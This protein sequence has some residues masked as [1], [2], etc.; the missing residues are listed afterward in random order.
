MLIFMPTHRRNWQTK[1]AWVVF[2]WLLLTLTPYHASFGQTTSA[3]LSPNERYREVSR[4]MAQRKYEEAVTQSKALIEEFPNYHN[5]YFALAM[6]ASEA[7]QL[8][9]A[10][11]WL[12][13]Q[14]ARIP[15]RPM[16]RVGLAHVSNARSDFSA[17]IE[18]YQNYLQLS[19]DD[20]RAA[21]LLAS[22]YHNQKKS[23]AGENYFKSLLAVRPYSAT[24]H[25]GLGVLYT[26]LDRRAEALAELNQVVGLQ[27]NTII[28]YSN[29]AFVLSREGRNS[30]GI[31]KLLLCLPL[32]QA[33]PDDLLERQL[34]TQLGDLYRRA[35]N[36]VAAEHTLGRLLELARAADDQRLEEAALG[37]LGSLHFRQSNY[38]E[39]LKYWRLALDVSRTIAS[40]KSKSLTYPHRHLDGI[41]SVYY[42]LGD[43]ESAERTYLEALRL[44][45]EAKDE[46]HQSRLLISLGDLY[47]ERG[48]FSEA[49]ST[50]QLAMAK[51]EKLA[52]LASRLGAL[53]SLS[54]LHR[55]LGDQQQALADV[56][57]AL[58]ILEGLTEPLWQGH[59]WNNLGNLHL[60]FREIPAAIIAFQKTLAIDQTTL[61]PRIIWD[62]N[63]GLADAYAQLGQL[64]NA[65][66]HYELA[67][68]QME[69]TR[70]NLGGEVEKA[71]FFQDKIAVY[72]KLIALLVNAPTKGPRFGDVVAFNYVERAR[73]RAFLDLLAEARVDVNENTTPDLLK[74]QRE[75]Q[76]RISQ[77]TSQLIKERSAEAD[78]QNKLKV[79]DLEN[80]LGQADA[81][82]SDWLRELRRR[83]P[84][85]AELKYPEP[86]TLVETQRMLDHET[87]LLSYSLGESESF[88]FAVSRTD[89]QVKRLPAEKTLEANVQKLL[90]AIT[91]KNNPAPAE[92]R[93]H[94][95]NLS[96]QLLQ[97]VSRMLDGKKRLI[98]VADGALHRLPF[99]VLFQPGVSQR[100]DLRQSP[101]LIRQFAI[102]YAP[103]AS[104]LAQLQNETHATAPKSFIAFGDPKYEPASEGGLASTLRVASASGR[105]N[106]QPLPYSRS[107]IDGIAQLFPK[108]DRELFFGE[109]A[110][111]ENVKSPDRLGAYRLIHFSTHGYVNEAR[112]RFSGLVL[113]LPA[114][115][116]SARAG[117]QSEDGLLAAYEI[118][119]LK[120]KADLV[121]LSACETGLGKEIK[122]EGLMSLTRAFMYAGA[123]SVVVSLWNVNDETAADLMIRFYRHLQSGKTKSEALRQAQLE[124]I[125][126]NGF[127][128]FWAPFVLI[129]KP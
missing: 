61:P 51:G 35:G 119:N 38:L 44:S 6:A 129:G 82:L 112:P 19:P 89:F 16:A 58:K 128:F 122:G 127:P 4:L 21:A 83:N 124:T 65:R 75:L 109:A 117:K 62:A 27:G 66:R 24:G 40:R 90:A 10:R 71:G 96:Q 11:V 34:L 86:V 87:V 14:L 8:E 48:K 81:E 31:A 63:A 43:L 28:S 97:P 105:L 85:Y 100:G 93:R 115:A 18:H 91:D 7:G 1:R 121:V 118:F 78:K 46:R 53:N 29:M 110:T 79:A 60:H 42:G 57:R 15:A 55:Q 116:A 108:D 26:H 33:N 30:E 56:Q 107:E 67:I 22:E 49:L 77:L 98:I 84:R 113:S 106:F 25:Q 3:S 120:L 50:Y 23:V 54:T 45:A 104:V 72:K 92:Y 41:G 52:D 47:T 68:N 99:E 123:P 94:A 59:S 13:S 2:G 12:E 5:G 39:A 32:L 125:R 9:S 20:D 36:H 101:F 64:E 73:A 126:D 103:S 37:Q 80:S 102:S 70:A 111:E 88:L 76:Q 114:S 74:R 95:A 17:A 69:S